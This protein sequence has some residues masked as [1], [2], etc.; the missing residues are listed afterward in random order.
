MWPRLGLMK[1]K[2][3]VKMTLIICIAVVIVTLIIMA[4]ITGNLDKLI[5]IWSE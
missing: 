5:G 4:G 1:L 2:P 3:K